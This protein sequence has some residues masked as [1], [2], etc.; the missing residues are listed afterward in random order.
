MIAVAWK[1]LPRCVLAEAGVE[2]R[3]GLVR[4]PYRDIEGATH[5]VRLFAPPGRCWWERT[6]LPLRPFGL[7]TLRRP[8]H[9]RGLLVAEGESDALALRA[10]FSWGYDVL[11]V[12][13]ATSWHR[14]WRSYAEPY[15]AVYALGDGDEAGRR[16]AA[17]VRRDVPRARIV[18]IPADEDARSLLQREGP[19]AL[20]W[21]LEEADR[22]ARLERELLGEAAYAT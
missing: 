9:D 1:G 10:S 2:V 11:G 16:L 20:D 5:N 8:P 15:A 21:L 14:E 18:P 13:G 6:G 19:G 12:P 3:D 7:E 4:V 17:S 22:L